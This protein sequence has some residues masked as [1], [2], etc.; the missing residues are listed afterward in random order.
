MQFS[1]CECSKY[2][3]FLKYDSGQLYKPSTR[4]FEVAMRDISSA[5][6]DRLRSIWAYW[7][8]EVTE[9]APAEADEFHP[10]HVI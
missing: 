10:D 9:D 5:D 6:A 1:L 4:D 2:F 3:F 7:E 8:E